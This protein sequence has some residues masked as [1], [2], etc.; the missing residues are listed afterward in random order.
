MGIVEIV[1]GANRNS[2]KCKS[3]NSNSGHFN[4]GNCISGNSYGGKCNSVSLGEKDL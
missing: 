1:Y 2:R 4:S 3:L